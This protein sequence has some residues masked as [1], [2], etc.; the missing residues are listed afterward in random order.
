MADFV[1]KK[2]VITGGTAGV[3][4]ASAR[5]FACA[6]A[7]V[8]VLAR[9]QDGLEATAREIEQLGGRPL[10]IEADVADPVQVEAAAER[11]E[12]E[13]GG[14]DVW[15]NNAMASVL[16]PI[17]QIPAEEFRRV[18]EVTY[19]GCVHGTQSAL[20]RMRPRD[21]GVIVQ[22]G[23]ALAYR[24]IPLQAPYCAAKH[25]VK[26]FT[27]ALRCELLHE[28]SHVE[29]TMVHLPAMNTPQFGW[30]RTRMPRR[31][32]PVPPIYQ[33]EVGARAIVWAAAHPRREIWVGGPTMKAI[34]AERIAPGVADRVLARQGYDDQQHD[35]PPSPDRRDNLWGPVPGDHGA[36]GTFGDRSRDSSRLLWLT[37]HRNAVLIAALAGG[38]AGWLMWP[39]REEDGSPIAAGLRKGELS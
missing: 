6:G 37:M 5:A 1:G 20:R 15:V 26:G 27:E 11:V 24:A 36:H 35:G 21:R 17:A 28:G 31:P 23:S 32:Q 12:R 14:I 29:L 3:G 38:V 13:W 19:L 4:R 30:M 22:V 10:A 7:D 16:S 2:V 18:T 9:G 25:A 34:L 8:A 33:P 39:R